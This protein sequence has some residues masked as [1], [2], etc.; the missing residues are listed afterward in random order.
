MKSTQKILLVV[1]A[2]VFAVVVVLPWMGKSA[3]ALPVAGEWSYSEFLSH[4]DHDQVA[5][6]RLDPSSHVLY[7][8]LT[9]AAPVSVA[10]PGSAEVPASPVDLLTT[11]A[12]PSPLGAPHAFLPSNVARARLFWK[13][14]LPTSQA[15]PT[16][17]L[18]A[19]LE[20]HRVDVQV[21]TASPDSSDNSALFMVLLTTLLPTALIIAFLYWLYR[22]QANQ[23]SM[24]GGRGNFKA[25]NRVFKAVSPHENTARLSDVAGCEEV[26]TEVAEFITYLRDP[27]NYRRVNARMTRGILMVGPPGT[28]KTLIARALAG[29]ARVPFF[30]VSGSDFVEM[31]VG[32]GA[33]RVR[34]LFQAAK[35]FPAAIIFIDEIDAIGR[36]RSTGMGPGND[37]REQT[38]NQLLVEMSGFT[39]SQNIVVIAAT[40]RADVLDQALLRP[41]RFD[42]HI[43][44]PLPDRAARADILAEH[45]QKVP[46]ASD[47]NLDALARAT[48]GF[49]GADL[50]N[51]V[52]EAALHAG[53]RKSRLVALPDFNEAHD[54]VLMGQTRAGGIKNPRERKV[55]AYHEAGHAIVARMLPHSEPVHKITII[56]RG[57]AMGMTVQLSEEENL[58]HDSDM[59]E[60]MLRVLMGGRAAEQVALK[61]QTVGASNDFARASRLA[62]LMVGTWGMNPSLGVVVFHDQ[63]ANIQPVRWSEAWQTRVDD[64][65][66]E[67]VNRAYAQAHAILLD[68]QTLLEAVAQALLTDETLDAAEFEAFVQTHGVDVPVRPVTV[69]LPKPIA[70]ISSPIAPEVSP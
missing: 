7:A 15:L 19:S 69:L 52:N 28:G 24:M 14:A 70:L 2:V 6:V 3:T 45:A 61:T 34:E 46:L 36:S 44:V 16:D 49:S 40:N 56:P 54:K 4:V 23:S 63:E 30:A 55:V 33:S 12:M 64:E 41:G 65:V 57:Q 13:V 25:M 53:R 35:Q 32:V 38:L 68:Q 10:S 17:G 39:Q 5:Q 20:R 42:R 67:T 66:S 22:R 21:M 31:F 11:Q 59:L 26:K 48:V 51:L 62:R 29:E 18:L 60:T 58:N 47:V 50:S 27:E 43:Q 37:E 8:L 9:E 1:A